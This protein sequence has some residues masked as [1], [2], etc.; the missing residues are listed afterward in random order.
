MEKKQHQ[1]PPYPLRSLWPTFLQS[2]P[3]KDGS[4]PY[5]A[6]GLETCYIKVCHFKNTIKLLSCLTALLRFPPLSPISPLSLPTPG[7]VPT[8][9]FLSHSFAHSPLW[10]TP[11]SLHLLILHPRLLGTSIPEPAPRSGPPS[12]EGGVSSD[13]PPSHKCTFLNSMG[14]TVKARQYHLQNQASEASVHT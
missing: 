5:E 11:P 9:L 4:A 14:P 2:P 10:N 6:P 7:P 3:W 1:S 8:P 12:L 13:L